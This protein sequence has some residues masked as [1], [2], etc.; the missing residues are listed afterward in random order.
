[1]LG[2]LHPVAGEVLRRGL[3]FKNF[4]NTL[5]NFFVTI[6]GI[7]GSHHVY[8]WVNLSL[9]LKIYERRICAVCSPQSFGVKEVLLGF[10]HF[11]F[12]SFL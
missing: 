10:F 1:V 7:F 12:S 9:S 8:T 3:K 4:T 5:N 11:R 6:P 2:L